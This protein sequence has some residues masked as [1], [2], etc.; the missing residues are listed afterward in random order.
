MGFV[1]GIGRV[2]EV[3]SSTVVNIQVVKD[4]GGLNATLNWYAGEWYNG[5][6]PTAVDIYE[7][8]VWYGRDD[9]IYGSV[10]DSY[11]SHDESIEGNSAAIKKTI[12]F[13]AV[14]SLRWLR[15]GLRLM[16]GTL[17][18][19]ITMRSSSYGEVLTAS[20]ANIKAGTNQ[21]SDNVD[22]VMIDNVVY[23]VQRSGVKLFSMLT[24]AERDDASTSD[25]NVLNRNITKSGIVRIAFTRQPETRLYCVLADGAMGVHTVDDS[26]EVAAWS[27]LS[28]YGLI[29]DVV[30]LPGLKEDQVYIVV[31][32]NSVYSLQRMAMLSESTEKAKDSFVSYSSAGTTLSGLDHL[33]GEVV[34]VIGDKELVGSFT[35]DSGAIT[36]PKSYASACVGLPYTASYVSNKLSG[37]RDASVLAERKR[38]ISTG[39]VL[40]D[41]YHKALT[42]GP[43]DSHMKNIPRIKRGNPENDNKFVANYDQLPF[44]F[45]GN[46]QSDPRVHIKATA[47]CT[48]LALTYE[49]DELNQ[50][51]RQ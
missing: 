6:Y 43:T 23:F 8:R 20:N 47:P 45:D 10:S 21:G 1:A 3:V 17:L 26:E 18:D 24:F 22:P 51:T 33:E 44:P 41:Y 37:Y 32:R 39:V 25:V 19:E 40:M 12:G 7:G 42:I 14:S 48:I 5:Y 27:R 4:F 30:V 50:Q 28:I 15:S 16:L 35:V 49:L 9:K 38:V 31:Y 2:T 34:E 29:K 13:G 11:Y 46:T 36:V